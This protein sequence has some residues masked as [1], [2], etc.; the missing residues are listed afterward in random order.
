MARETQAAQN[1][2]IA[3]LE[4]AMARLAESEARL[5]QGKPGNRAAEQADWDSRMAQMRAEA[6]E[7]EK[8]LDARID[9]LLADIRAYLNRMPGEN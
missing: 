9:K 6:R 4:A 2:R 5:A 7:R 3:R 8:R 1:A